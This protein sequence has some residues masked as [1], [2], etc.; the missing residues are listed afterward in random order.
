MAVFLHAIIIASYLLLATAVALVAPQLVGWL[1]PALA[2][3]LGGIVFV[4]ASVMH[5]VFTQSER[6]RRVAGEMAE[7]RARQHRLAE[8][9]VVAQTDALQLRQALVNAGE[10]GERRVSE[11]VA[12]VKVLQDLVERF[13]DSQAGEPVIESVIAT[14]GARPRL[15]ALAGGRLPEAPVAQLPERDPPPEPANTDEA[16]TL[17]IIR[18]AL[19]L[20]RVDVYLQSVVSLPQRKHRFHE[21]FTRL[22][23]EDGRVV[24]PNQYLDIAAR[25]GLLTAVDNMLL[26][27]CVQLVR[28]TQRR[29]YK[30]AFFCNISNKTL[31]DTSFFRDFVNFVLENDDL[32][33]KLFFEFHQ[34]DM[35]SPDDETLAGLERLASLGFRFSLDQV[36]DLDMDLAPLAERGFKFIKIDA[37]ELLQGADDDDDD[38]EGVDDTIDA[39]ALKER[40]D[41]HEIDLIVEKIESEQQLLEL[42][43]FD[44]D[45]GQGYLFGEP[46]LSREG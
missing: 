11:V 20:D 38:D 13:Y 17:E 46:R 8:D 15:V 26:F 29:N 23:A 33:P 9:L 25:H 37:E 34:A 14:A 4:L 41:H 6:Q 16:R 24:L 19:R 10:M 30:T 7:V 21:C 40:L 32:A 31:S 36:T 27:R 3:L 42:L 22:R 44:I 12:E 35:V 1:T 28:R 43:D 2:P 5:L 18:E 39:G 45:Y